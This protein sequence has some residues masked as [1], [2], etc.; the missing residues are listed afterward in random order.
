MF[1]GMIRHRGVVDALRLTPS[2]RLVLR[3]PGL[4]A[5]R[6]DSVAVDGVCLTVTRRVGPRL[7]FD[8]LAETLRVTTLGRRR[9]GDRVN[10]EPAL[11]LGDALGGHWVLGHVDGVG[12][13]TRRVPSTGGLT[14]TITAPPAVRRLLAPKGSIAVD[15][16]SLTVG[17]RMAAGAF[18]V[19]LIPH[20]AAAT[21][22]GTRR[23]GDLVNLEGDPIARYAK[24]C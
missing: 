8:L 11:R 21:T 7:T 15:G 1:T 18:A 6:G 20:T 13:V 12:R 5:R 14:V 24:N 16:V 10:L 19:F 17:P 2:P 23:P 3:A 9:P 22:L 4:R